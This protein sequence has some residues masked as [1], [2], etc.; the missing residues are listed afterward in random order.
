[1]HRTSK[2]HLYHTKCIDD[3]LALGDQALLKI[4]DEMA[5]LASMKV[6][7]SAHTAVVAVV[8]AAVPALRNYQHLIIRLLRFL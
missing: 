2:L 5:R 4:E 8:V 7:F 1:M 3:H 6:G